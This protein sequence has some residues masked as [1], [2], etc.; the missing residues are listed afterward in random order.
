MSLNH[1]WYKFPYFNSSLSCITCDLQFFKQQF[2]CMK[3][4]VKVLGH[5]ND[6]TF[7]SVTTMTD[8][9]RSVQLQL[10]PFVK[11]ICY[12]LYILGVHNIFSP[13]D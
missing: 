13:K 10:A 5:Q 6:C 4:S 3:Y 1:S 9:K 12:S 8:M 11:N 7:S 2:Y